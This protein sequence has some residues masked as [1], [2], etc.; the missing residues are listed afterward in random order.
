ML[1]EIVSDKNHGC[2]IYVD[3]T[4]PRLGQISTA[5]HSADADI[6]AYRAAHVSFA[7]TLGM[8]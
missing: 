3:S 4:P 6:I 7:L 5:V 2:L 8:N 1:N